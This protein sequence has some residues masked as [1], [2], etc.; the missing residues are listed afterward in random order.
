MSGV[1]PAHY[2]RKKSCRISLAFRSHL[3]DVGAD[4]PLPASPRFVRAYV[5]AAID[6]ASTAANNRLLIVCVNK[7]VDIRLVYESDTR[8][9]GTSSYG[10]W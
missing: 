2:T 6:P 8:Q 7:G 9:V 3:S 10:H 4:N 5:V 1:L